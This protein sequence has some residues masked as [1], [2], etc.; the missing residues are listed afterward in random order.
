MTN[1]LS[2]KFNQIYL[3][4]EKYLFKNQAFNKIITLKKYIG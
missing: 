3:I 2:C 1:N 4:K